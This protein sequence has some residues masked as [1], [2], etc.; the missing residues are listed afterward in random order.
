MVR[1]SSIKKVTPPCGGLSE[2]RSGVLIVNVRSCPIAD[3]MLQCRECPL[4]ANSGH[5]TLGEMREAAN[6][7]GLSQRDLGA[8]IRRFAYADSCLARLR[9]R[10]RKQNS[11]KYAI[12]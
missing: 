3:K 1:R 9:A 7:G 5:C 6:W 12:R 4:C 8:A 11:E 10:L 2:I